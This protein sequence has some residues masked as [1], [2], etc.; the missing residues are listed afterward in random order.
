MCFVEWPGRLSGIGTSRPVAWLLMGTYSNIP[1]SSRPHSTLRG[2]LPS[3][4]KKENV[5]LQCVATN[6]GNT[7]RLLNLFLEITSG[8][9][10]VPRRPGISSRLA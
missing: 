4:P 7:G 2:V 10:G 1:Y 9:G 6:D 3:M 5:A 8:S